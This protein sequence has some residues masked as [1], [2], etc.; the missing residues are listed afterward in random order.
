MNFFAFSKAV[1]A[2]VHISHIYFFRGSDVVVA[3][4]LRSPLTSLVFLVFSFFSTFSS[5]GSL[6]ELI[7][8]VMRRC[9]PR[10]SPS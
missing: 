1:A 6:L 2:L 7:L 9:A 8:V 3:L 10:P 5:F 4:R